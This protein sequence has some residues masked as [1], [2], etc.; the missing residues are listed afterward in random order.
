MIKS[1]V[2]ELRRDLVQT[3]IVI[4]IGFG[5]RARFHETLQHLSTDNEV[6]DYPALTMLAIDTYEL[7][8]THLEFADG[9]NVFAVASAKLD[10]SGKSNSKETAFTWF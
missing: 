4:E 8:W 9:A 5:V 6:L 3:M 10:K 7:K 1:D 2:L